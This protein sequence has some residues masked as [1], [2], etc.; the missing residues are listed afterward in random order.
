[1]KPARAPALAAALTR[2][3]QVYN[4]G[5]PQEDIEAAFAASASFFALP[6]EVKARTPFASWAGGWEKEQQARARVASA[7][8]CR[9]PQGGRARRRRLRPGTAGEA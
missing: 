4:H 2:R 8:R 6:D 3:A 9:A 1:M 7:R 5:V